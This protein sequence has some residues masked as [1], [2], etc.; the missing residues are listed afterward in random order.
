MSTSQP[1]PQPQPTPSETRMVTPIEVLYPDAGDLHLRIAEGACRLN[2]AP[3]TSDAWIR[4]SQRDPSGLRPLHVSQEGGTVRL[5]EQPTTS[6]VW[7]WLRAGHGFADV[8]AI[9]LALGTAKP[10]RLTVEIGASENRLDLGGVPLSRLTVR[11][12]AGKTAI[13]FSSP[14][15]QPMTLME[16][17][18]GAGS[19][20][21]RNLANAHAAE[22]LVE[23]GMASYTLD[24]GGILQQDTH[25]RITAAL[26]SV[27]ITVPATTAARISTESPL[28]HVELGDGFTAKE[29]A[30]WTPAAV[31][32]RTP[33]LTISAN[34][35][36]G[37]LSLRV[38]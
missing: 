38:S 8:P 37:S 21:L 25:T 17:G 27:E 2:I 19:T 10:F 15:P 34:V 4:G 1:I 7:D 22:I 20:E 5:S 24:F 30:F 36:L 9:D 13:D 12:G 3:G 6:G 11:H 26:S 14:N 33:T 35:T 18:A 32:G 28:G 29:G 16:I 31:E 23:G